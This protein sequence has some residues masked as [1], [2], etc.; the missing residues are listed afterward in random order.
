MDV[1]AEALRLLHYPPEW[2]A[3]GLP[4]SRLLELQLGT[5]RSSGDQ[6]TEHYRY[7]AFQALLPEAATHD[8]RFAQ[9]LVLVDADPDPAMAHSALIELLLR[10]ELSDA[11]FERVAQH[12]WLV[13]D[14]RLP[15]RHRLV[16]ALRSEGPTPDLVARCLA[17]GDSGVHWALLGLGGLPRSVLEQL[18]LNGASRRVRNMA[19]AA[20]RTKRS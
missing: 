11:R 19:A 17:E 6:H 13:E 7:A 8:E 12:P 9:Y 2:E 10:P 15:K 1:R 4:D 3:F 14:P 18:A 20:L 5:F 16:R